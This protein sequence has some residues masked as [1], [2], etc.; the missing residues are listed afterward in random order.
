MEKQK[1]CPNGK[2]MGIPFYMEINKLQ[3]DFG[4]ISSDIPLSQLFGFISHLL[5]KKL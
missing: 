2:K 1:N 5:R 3:L 4:V